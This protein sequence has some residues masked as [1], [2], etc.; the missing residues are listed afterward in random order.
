MVVFIL[1]S[2]VS[3]RVRGLGRLDLE[4]ENVVMAMDSESAMVLV[5]PG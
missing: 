5:V 2:R 4:L 3:C 1:R